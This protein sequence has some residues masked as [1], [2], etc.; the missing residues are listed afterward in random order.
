M[1]LEEAI[2]RGVFKEEEVTQ[3]RLKQFLSGYG[4]KFCILSNGAKGEIMLEGKGERVLGSIKS[5]D[6]S[7]EVALSMGGDNVFSLSWTS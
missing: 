1:A 3:Q 7:I 5:K 2:E 4:R 6:G